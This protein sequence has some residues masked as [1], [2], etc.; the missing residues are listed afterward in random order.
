MKLSREDAQT[1]LDFAM[2][3]PMRNAW[4]NLFDDELAIYVRRG[5]HMWRGQMFHTFD[6]ANLQIRNPDERGKGRFTA[7]FNF[8]EPRFN[9]FIESIE[10]HGLIDFCQKRGLEFEYPEQ[11]GEGYNIPNAMSIQDPDFSWDDKYSL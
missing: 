5:R 3:S 8:L 2:L 11:L 10:N 1:L 9:V 7:V 4:L 6:L